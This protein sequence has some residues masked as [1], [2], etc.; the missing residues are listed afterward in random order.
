M[1]RAIL[2]AGALLLACSPLQ[3]Q[4]TEGQRVRVEAPSEGVYSPSAAR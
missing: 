4:F 2:A 3:A 1:I